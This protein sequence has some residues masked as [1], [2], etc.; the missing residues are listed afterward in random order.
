MVLEGATSDGAVEWHADNA[1]DDGNI[2]AS[3]LG[4]LTLNAAALPR[5]WSGYHFVD[6]VDSSSSMNILLGRL[7]TA[8]QCVHRPLRQEEVDA[9]STIHAKS[10]RTLSFVPS[11]VMAS[12]V[13]AAH[14]TRQDYGLPFVSLA[15][16]KWFDPNRLLMV[17]G[18]FARLGWQVIR[19][20]AYYIG[21]TL[22][23]S[24]FMVSYSATVGATEMKRDPRLK[25]F[26]E[27]SI[28]EWNQQRSTASQKSSVES[29]D[30]RM[31]SQAVRASTIFERAKTA[32]QGNVSQSKYGDDDMS[33]TRGG[34]SDD[35][36]TSNSEFGGLLSDSQ[37]QTNERRQDFETKRAER[38]S[39]EEAIRRDKQQRLGTSGREDVFEQLSGRQTPSTGSAWDRIRQRAAEQQASSPSSAPQQRQQALSDRQDA[40]RDFDAKLDQER[41]GGDFDSQEGRKRW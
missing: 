17:R 7:Q 35:L 3:P 25:E 34:F 12:T 29:S 26:L 15:K 6:F 13:V 19:F 24:T 31:D 4:D 5:V 36:Q 28:A 8:Q 33:P 41:R 40:Q 10:A 37:M 23:I 2:T 39:E 21:F 38:A 20:S 11:I 32:R 16:Q 27:A 30:G 18:P 22:G 14:R 9:L 1:V